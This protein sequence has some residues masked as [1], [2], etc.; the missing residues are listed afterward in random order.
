MVCPTCYQ[1]YIS[2]CHIGILINAGLESDTDYEWVIED[3]FDHG[4]SGLFTTD[5]EGL[6][7]IDI[8]ELPEGLFTPYSGFFKLRILSP[9]SDEYSPLAINGTTYDCIEFYVKGGTENKSYLGEY[10]EESV[11]S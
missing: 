7:I 2:S 11:S 1:D 8:S 9:D 10:T 5:G 6:G 4:Y 3:K